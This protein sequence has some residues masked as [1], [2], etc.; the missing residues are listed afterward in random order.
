MNEFPRKN[1]FG[2]IEGPLWILFSLPLC[3]VLYHTL[4]AREWGVSCLLL[5]MIILATRIGWVTTRRNRR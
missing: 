5:I 3:W 2:R 1:V 4:R